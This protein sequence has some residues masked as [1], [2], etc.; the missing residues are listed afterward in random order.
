MVQNILYQELN[1]WGYNDEYAFV[2]DEKPNI[3]TDKHFRYG[4][5]GTLN[6]LHFNDM[7]VDRLSW[8]Y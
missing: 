1:D 6:E 4:G 3:N 2:G 7:L 8:D 5:A